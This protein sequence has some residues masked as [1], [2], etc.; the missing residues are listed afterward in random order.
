MIPSL[1]N[2]AYPV[3]PKIAEQPRKNSNSNTSNEN[4]SFKRLSTPKQVSFYSPADSSQESTSR[5]ERK[6]QVSD[7]KTPKFYKLPEPPQNIF[8]SSKERLFPDTVRKEPISNNISLLLSKVQ[9]PSTSQAMSP[10]TARPIHQ[11][12]PLLVT[13]RTIEKT[14]RIAKETLEKKRCGILRMKSTE[15]L[16]GSSYYAKPF[17]I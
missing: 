9:K 1:K 10:K 5:D 17:V 14:Q 16:K 4:V 7:L 6:S 2:T 12:N 3:F 11:K 8:L 13:S 15:L